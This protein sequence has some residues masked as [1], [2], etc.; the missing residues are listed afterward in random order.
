VKPF[1]HL[2]GGARYKTLGTSDLFRSMERV[3]RNTTDIF[4][5][6]LLVSSSH[7]M[8]SENTIQSRNCSVCGTLLPNKFRLLKRVA[9]LEPLVTE[10][11]SQETLTAESLFF[12][13]LS[14]K[15]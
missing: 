9:L 1:K 3:K 5:T 4:A 13:Y 2:K 7:I 6:L 11:H 15:S 14:R 12:C 10:V 8:A